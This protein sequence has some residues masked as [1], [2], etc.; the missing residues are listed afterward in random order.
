MN[1]YK[2][3]NCHLV[4]KSSFEEC[5]RCGYEL[6]APPGK[7]AVQKAPS[8]GPSLPVK[9]AI[10][11]VLGFVAYSYFGGSG[12]VDQTAVPAKKPATQ[13]QPTLSLRSE[14]EQ[15]QT[16]AYKNAVQ[17][18]PNLAQSQKRSEETQK[19]MQSEPV[20]SPK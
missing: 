7:T 20:K 13:P 14:Y 15:R 17:S 19:L 9:L 2:C 8:T 3:R 12:N 4:N 11:C 18:S 6:V 5:Q 10:C 16:G 1:V